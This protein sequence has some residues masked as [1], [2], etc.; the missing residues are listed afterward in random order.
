M[1]K[2]T[3]SKFT[4]IATPPDTEL[5][6]AS[7]PSNISGFQEAMALAK[8]LRDAGKTKMDIARA[9]YPSI[10]LESKEVVHLALMEGCL[11]T[12]KGAVTY[13]YNLLR[14]FKQE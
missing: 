11:L 6:P 5:N 12:E 14:E 13:R 7:L 4:A 1:F 8:T 9:I 10:A 2:N 3:L